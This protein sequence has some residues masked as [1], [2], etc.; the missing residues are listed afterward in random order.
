MVF[1]VIS[2]R[3]LCFDIGAAFTL[4]MFVQLQYLRY[5]LTMIVCNF[6]CRR[7]IESKIDIKLT[8]ERFITKFI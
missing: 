8:C 5:I 3:Y 4:C 2:I 7:T 6:A 1:N